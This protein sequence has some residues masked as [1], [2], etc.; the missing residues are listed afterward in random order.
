MGG[1]G[2]ITALAARDY[3]VEGTARVAILGGL[4]PRWLSNS[5]CLS[6]CS[7]TGAAGLSGQKVQHALRRF[8]IEAELNSVDPVYPARDFDGPHSI[9]TVVGELRA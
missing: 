4:W 7:S 2:T 1:G 5:Y 9:V 6:R 8:D 3:P